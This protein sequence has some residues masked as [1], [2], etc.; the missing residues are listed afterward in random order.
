MSK[1]DSTI[2]TSEVQQAAFQTQLSSLFTAQYAKQASLMAF[3]TPILEAGV[4]NPQGMSPAALV[5]ARTG[6]TDEVATQVQSAQRGANAVAASHGGAALPSGVAAQVGGDIAA[7][8]AQ[9]TAKEQSGITLANEN[10]KQQNYWKSLSGLAGLTT[11][12]S[13]DALAGAEIGSGQATGQ[14]GSA[15]LA[16]KNA[17]FQD[18][19]NG[20]GGLG[21]A[22][23]SILTGVGTM[24]Q[25]SAMKG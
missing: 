20:I 7:A 19:I 13:P 1:T 2:K 23:G 24:Q 12:E 25:A 11:A 9:E 8:G 6:A 21:G 14:E 15:Y 10:L 5:A 16:S 4:T 3:A 18:L 22:A 17:T